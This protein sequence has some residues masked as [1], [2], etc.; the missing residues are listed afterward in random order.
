MKKLL[1]TMLALMLVFALVGCNNNQGGGE[2]EANLQVGIVLPTKDEPRWLQDEASFS[3]ILGDAGFTS[4]VM[5]S[6]GSPETELKNVESLIEKGVKA[7]VI[8]AHDATA[9]GAA[10]QKARDAGIKVICYDRLI[11]DTDAVDYYVTFNSF[12]VG[13]KQGEYLI[14]AYE[15]KTDVPLY[16][17]SGAVT[18]NNAFIF[19]AGA[20]SVLNQAVANGQF[21]VVNCPEIADYSGKA[22]SETADRDVLSKILGTITT[23]WDFN[24]AKSLAEGNLAANS[25]ADKGD[26]AILA[27]NDGTARAIA[28]AM[29]ADG[30]ITSW[31]ITGQDA[32]AA[33]LEYIK[34]GKQSMT[35]W[36]NTADLAKTTCDMVNAILGGGTPSTQ[37]KYN[38]GKIEVPS[39]ETPVT[40]VTQDNVDIV[41]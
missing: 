35:V 6:Q 33:S 19:F 7:I 26:V 32:E 16:L 17:Y 12:D 31:V 41:K 34:E 21:R 11:T 22:L 10:V 8:C 18:D 29:A 28:D 14:K 5:F 40:V 27:P 30:D 37:A 15:G 9:A 2:E 1:M 38:N 36:K 39:S 3:K 20:W 23:N 25:A 4:E 24:V 13:V